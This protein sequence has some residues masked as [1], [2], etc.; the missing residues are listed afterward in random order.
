M[1]H[2]RATDASARYN[3]KIKELRRVASPGE[4]FDVTKSRFI[5]LSGKNQYHIIFVTEVKP[6]GVEEAP[7]KKKRAKKSDK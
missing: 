4:E 1:V 5:T 2:V 6:E 7:E 3:I